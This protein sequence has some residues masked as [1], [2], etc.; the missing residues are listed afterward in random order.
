MFINEVLIKK[1][2]NVEI[3]FRRVFCNLYWRKNIVGIEVE[4][5]NEEWDFFNI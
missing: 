3:F 5:G 4:V 1:S 2:I